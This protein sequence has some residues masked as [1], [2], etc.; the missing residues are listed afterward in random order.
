MTTI[1]PLS[2]TVYH[3]A[4]MHMTWNKTSVELWTHEIHTI[5][6]PCGWNMECIL[7]VFWRKMLMLRGC[8]TVLTTR[9]AEDNCGWYRPYALAVACLDLQVIRGLWS[10]VSDGG[11]QGVA[12][13][14]LDHPVSFT[15][16]SISCV[17]HIVSCKHSN[18]TWVILV[19]IMNDIFSNALPSFGD[20]TWVRV[21]KI[22]W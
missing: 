3:T 20:E 1:K 21:L 4:I 19:S 11:R 8:L 6:R 15:L 12:M 18:V 10:E 5:P 14:P 2:N 22:P 9:C 13:N 16:S 17:E 7:W